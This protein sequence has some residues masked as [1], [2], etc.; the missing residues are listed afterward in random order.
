M[1]IREYL[2]STPFHDLVR[3]AEHSA[4]DA[5]AFTGTLRKHPYDTEKC[6]LLTSR[7]EKLPWIEEGVIIEFRMQDV[8]AADGLPSVVDEAGHARTSVR[9]WVRR[10]A[11]A[12]RYEPFEVGDRPLG[13]KESPALREKLSRIVASQQERS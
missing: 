7:Q 2:D 3:Y 10:G 11:I 8:V 1:S 13:P 9:I 4:L 5:V 12:L 6:L